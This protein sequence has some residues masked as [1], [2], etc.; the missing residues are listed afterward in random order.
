[1]NPPQN[2]PKLTAASSLR[3]LVLL[4]VFLYAMACGIGARAAQAD[5]SWPVWLWVGS[6][7]ALF[8]ESI[9]WFASSRPPGAARP[10]PAVLFGIGCAAI[11]LAPLRSGAWLLVLSAEWLVRPALWD[12]GILTHA[13]GRWAGRKAAKLR[14]LSGHAQKDGDAVALNAAAAQVATGQGRRWFRQA[15]VPASAEVRAAEARPPAGREVGMHL[16]RCVVHVMA[17]GSTH[18]EEVARE[19]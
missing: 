10:H 5:V 4:A 8:A 11:A 6:C 16:A 1:M 2:V 19:A 13:R 3:P 14:R 7:V 12:G 18:F 15:P 17:D 9:W